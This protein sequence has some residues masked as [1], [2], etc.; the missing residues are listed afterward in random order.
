MHIPRAEPLRARSMGVCLVGRHPVPF[1]GT[2]VHDLGQNATSVLLCT[3]SLGLGPR[4]LDDYLLM[5]SLTTS[6][7]STFFLGALCAFARD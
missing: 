1:E 7:S 3:H 6:N 2:Y 5:N 4:L